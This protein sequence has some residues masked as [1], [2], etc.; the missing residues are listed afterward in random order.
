VSAPCSAAIARRAIPWA[1]SLFRHAP[2]PLLERTFWS[3]S[4]FNSTSPRPRNAHDSD[5]ADDLRTLI[6]VQPN[7]RS[8]GFQDMRLEVTFRQ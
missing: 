6:P 3:P 7:E 4:G 5:L 1:Q 2:A 8:T